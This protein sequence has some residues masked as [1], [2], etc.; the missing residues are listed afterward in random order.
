MTIKRSASLALV[1]LFSS[2]FPAA[3]QA[4][5][6]PPAA[7]P[8]FAEA[9]SSAPAADSAVQADRPDSVTL[10]DDYP[11]K[12][13]SPDGVD[14]WGFYYRECTSFVAFR[15]NKV[16]NFHNT[17][18]GG[19]F[20]NAKNWDNNARQLGY[21]VDRKAT[22]GSVMVRDSGPFG[23]VAIVARVKPNRVLVEQYN[24]EGTHRYSREWVSRSG[25]KFIH[26]KQ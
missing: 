4:T 14:P 9:A 17:M 1:A 13:K 12:R 7:P 21:R 15:L 19:R 25:K 6:P 26:F 16:M 10:R 22:V 23:H 8:V 18:K 3:A 11:Y 24:F 20:S 5:V 2:L